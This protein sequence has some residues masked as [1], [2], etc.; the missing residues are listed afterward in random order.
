M[1]CESPSSE[2]HW[3][4]FLVQGNR[5]SDRPF[6]TPLRSKLLP[7]LKKN[8]KEY[9][10]LNF[11][12]W[13]W[14]YWKSEIIW[15]RNLSLST[16]QA[17]WWIHGKRIQYDFCTRLLHTFGVHQFWNSLLQIQKN[18]FSKW[19]IPGNAWYSQLRHIVHIGYVQLDYMYRN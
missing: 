5:R 19:N 14:I 6:L 12:Y 11:I 7:L 17:I 8:I 10:L 18:F 16:L 4:W 1:Y 13:V 3:H 9:L 2:P 15:V